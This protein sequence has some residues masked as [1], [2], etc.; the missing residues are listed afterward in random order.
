MRVLIPIA[1]L[2]TAASCANSTGDW[3]ATRL[4]RGM[5][6]YQQGDFDAAKRDF[7]RLADHG[8]A[9]AE[10]MLGVMYARGK[11]VKPQPAVAAAYFY[12]AATRGYG[13]AQVALSKAYAAG[14]GVTR[15]GNE[16][17]FWALL[18]ATG[19]DRTAEAQAREQLANLEPATS[20]TEREK[21]ALRVENWRP[22]KTQTR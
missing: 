21:A 18:A 12:R 13:P 3:A 15:D 1:V 5:H 7:R 2:L 17:Y 9:I 4:D 6:P 20:R 19:G 22:R 11:G 10:T 14:R 8:S 16:A